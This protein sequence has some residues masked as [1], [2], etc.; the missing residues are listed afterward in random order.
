MI[1]VN[2]IHQCYR[3]KLVLQQFFINAAVLNAE[4]PLNSRLHILDVSVCLSVLC[5]LTVEWSRNTIA[6]CL[7][8]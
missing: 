5:Q 8:I 3:L 2:D 4:M 7:I 1:F 6:A